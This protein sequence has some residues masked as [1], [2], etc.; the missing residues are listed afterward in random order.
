[1]QEWMDDDKSLN[2]CINIKLRVSQI[3]SHVMNYGKQISV[4]NF[5]RFCGFLFCGDFQRQVEIF[6]VAAKIDDA[7]EG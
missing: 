4:E 6:M 3:K 5:R 2:C 7:Q 1:M